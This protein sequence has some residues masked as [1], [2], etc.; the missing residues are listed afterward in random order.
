MPTRCAAGKKVTSSR[1]DRSL[2]LWRGHFD[3]FDGYSQWNARN[4]RGQA[5]SAGVY[6]YKIQVGDK[7]NTRKIVLLK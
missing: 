2:R 5:V 7:M 6:L 4:D 1:S 3:H